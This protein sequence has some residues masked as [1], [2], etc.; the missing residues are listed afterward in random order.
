MTNMS[1]SNDAQPS[2][3]GAQIKETEHEEIGG[4]EPSGKPA[5]IGRWTFETRIVREI[6]LDELEGRVLNACAGKTKLDKEGVEIVR[7]DINPEIDAD[8]HLDIEEIDTVFDEDSFDVVV[9]DPPF[10][11]T[12]SDEH[13]DGLHARNLGRA[14]Q[15][16]VELIR[17][18]GKIVELGWSTWSASDFSQDF[19]EVESIHLRRAMPGRKPIFVTVDR[20]TQKPLV[21]DGG[22]A[23][24][25]DGVKQW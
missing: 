23:R 21:A 25:R 8:Y 24:P 5:A 4:K 11:Q 17:P 3:G 20:R 12:Q 6:I 9:L 10:D 14:R 13:Y 22:T 15:K 2:G 1:D 18:G 7:N 19:D 16:L